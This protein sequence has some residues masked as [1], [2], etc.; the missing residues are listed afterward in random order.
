M[1]RL[2]RLQKVSRKTIERGLIVSILISL[3]SMAVLSV[4][5]SSDETVAALNT[6][7]KIHLLYGMLSIFL[8]WTVQALRIEVLARSFGKGVGFIYAFKVY[9]ISSFVAH[10]T[11]FSSGG[12][13]VEVYLLYRK[14]ISLA[15]SSAI[16][17][18]QGSLTALFLIL[19]S[20]V[21]LYIWRN[22]FGY[23]LGANAAFVVVLVIVAAFIYLF[24]KPSAL[25]S[26]LTSILSVGPISRFLTRHSLEDRANGI[27]E[28]AYASVR[29][30][31][32]S[33]MHLWTE[34]RSTLIVSALLTVLYWCCYLSVVPIIFAGL[35]LHVKLANAVLPQLVFNLL[36]AFIPT[37]GGSG[38]AE[39]GF[40]SLYSVF[41]PAAKL[42]VFVVLWRFF[43]F[44]LSLFCGGITLLFVMRE[45]GRAH[46][47]GLLDQ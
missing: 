41:V 45:L 37:P 29:Q 12:L 26:L 17:L 39:L 30:F 32:E 47:E 1:G 4:V 42:A 46:E 13:P 31:S 9:L 20:P 44:Y 18:V 11:P 25:K 34:G 14:G 33:L 15:K 19:V 6:A 24:V 16:I 35:G 5:S 40:A 8:V 22:Q 7:S 3:L 27:V 36:Q 10:V 21:L 38:G 23:A 43:T 28:K 2:V